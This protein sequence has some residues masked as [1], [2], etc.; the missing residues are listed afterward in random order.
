MKKHYLSYLIQCSILLMFTGCFDKVMI[1]DPGIY[2]LIIQGEK[3]QVP[4]LIEV[5]DQHNFYLLRGNEKIKLDRLNIKY[6]KSGIIVLSMHIYNSELI[7][8]AKENNVI[9]GYWLRKDKHPIQKIP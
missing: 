5:E 1:L 9:K 8:E 2:R 3:A 4:A 6:Q 7:L